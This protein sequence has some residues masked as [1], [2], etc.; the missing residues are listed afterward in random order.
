MVSKK[1]R[2]AIENDIEMFELEKRYGLTKSFSSKAAFLPALFRCFNCRKIL[3]NTQFKLILFQKKFG[4]K[5]K[6]LK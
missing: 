1:K 4:I 6:G 3:L 5:E 2:V